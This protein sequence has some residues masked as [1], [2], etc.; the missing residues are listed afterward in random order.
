M[1][2]SGLLILVLSVCLLSANL[3]Q[4]T[5]YYA[6]NGTTSD[7][8]AAGNWNVF[9][10]QN[11]AWTIPATSTPAATDVVCFNGYLGGN[12][13][14]S[15][16]IALPDGA[17]T[18]NTAYFGSNGTQLNFSN[19]AATLNVTGN[20]YFS[21]SPTTN[22]APYGASTFA[23]VLNVTGQFAPQLTTYGAILNVTSSGNTFAGGINVLG[24]VTNI[25]GNNNAISGGIT[26]IGTTFD[27]WQA[28]NNFA[29]MNGVLKFSGTGNTFAAQTITLKDFGCLDL[30]SAQDLSAI[31]A[32]NFN[33]GML[34]LDTTA[35]TFGAMTGG[36]NVKSGSLWITGDASLGDPTLN[37]IQLGG[38]NS[39]GMLTGSTD[40]PGNSDYSP[41]SASR[42]ITLN[43][44]GGV[45]RVQCNQ[46][47]PGYLA[48]LDIGSKITGSGTLIKIG[49][50]TARLMNSGAISPTNDYSGGTINADSVLY[51][52]TMRTL[53]TGNVRVEPGAD[54]QLTAGT[55]VAATAKVLVNSGTTG[56]MVYSGVLD[57]C[58]Y[59]ANW[60][61]TTPTPGFMPTIDPASTGIVR[62]TTGYNCGDGQPI[63]T[64]L[65]A[66]IAG[67]GTNGVVWIGA[68]NWSGYYGSAL[69][70]G[71]ALPT[72]GNKVYRFSSGAV[73]EE[74]G[75][76]I[77][78]G[79]LVG[80]T[81]VW[82]REGGLNL[83]ATNT[84]TG[85]L[86]V[87]NTLYH[88]GGWWGW[89]DRG[90]LQ[91]VYGQA[92]TTA[93]ASPL[94][95]AAGDVKLMGGLLGINSIAAGLGVGKHDL[96]YSGSSYV[97]LKGNA[98]LASLSL[99]SLTRVNNGGLIIFPQTSGLGTTEQLLVSGTVPTDPTTGMVAPY[100]VAANGFATGDF[101]TY[102]STTGFNKFDGYVGMPASGG[103][104]TE[105]VNNT[106]TA[107][108]ADT[109]VW[110]MKSSG[111][112][113]G[114]GK[115][116]TLGSG[117]L[118]LA[119]NGTYDANLKAGDGAK[120]LVVFVNVN[121]GPW[122]N[123]SVFN[124]T[125]TAGGLTLFGAGTIRM[126][127]DNTATL[128]GD[129][130]VNDG[131]IQYTND[132]QF[133]AANNSIILNGGTLW[134]SYGYEA[135]INH[136]IKVGPAGGY[137]TNSYNGGIDVESEISDLDPLHS[138][139]V[140]FNANTN[141]LGVAATNTGGT[142]FDWGQTQL[143]NSGQP[144][145]GPVVIGPGGCMNVMRST[146]PDMRTS[147]F[148]LIS[149][150][151]N[152][153]IL[154]MAES[155]V[156]IGSLSGYGNV[157]FG[158]PYD[159]TNDMTMYVGYDN[160]S[161]DFYGN[162]EAADCRTGYLD[163]EG[164][165]TLTLWGNVSL[166]GGSATINGG[167]LKINGLYSSGSRGA[168]SIIVNNT[169]IL[170]GQGTISSVTV[171]AG[172]LLTGGMAI[173][174]SVLVN[175]G[176]ANLNG[177]TVTGNLVVG[178]NNNI[179]GSAATIANS[180]LTGAV[181]LGG[182]G[183]F[184]STGTLTA[185]NVTINANTITVNKGTFTGT[186]VTVNGSSTVTIGTSNAAHVGNITGTGNNFNLTGYGYVNLVNGTI[187]GSNTF[188]SNTYGF[189]INSGGYAPCSITGSNT[190]TTP[191]NA[192]FSMGKT[193]NGPDPA[194][195]TVV[196]GSNTINSCVY[197]YSGTLIGP[198]TIHGNTLGALV[199]QP[200]SNAIVS[201]HVGGTASTLTIG[202]NVTL[203]H[204]TVLNFNLGSPGTTGSGINDLIDITGNL[205]LDGTLNVNNLSGFG[206]GTYRLFNYTG[207]L[208]GPGLLQGTMP[209]DL[210]Y[211]IDTSTPGQINL[212]V[213]TP[214]IPG[215]TDH[216]G[217]STLNTLDIDAI[218]AHFGAASTSQWKVYPDT[219][220]VGQE[221]VTYEVAHYML[222]NYADANLD[223]Y[224]DFTDFQVLLDHWQAP[225]GWGDG[226][227]NGDGTVDFLDFQVL[228]DYWNP[229]GWSAGASQVPEPASLS[230]LLLGGLA[231][232]RR[233]K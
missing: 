120:E 135:R 56:S 171:N 119:G 26:V 136:K 73:N 65:A 46:W 157:L 230:L 220:P 127:A 39:L 174:G 232:L 67:D 60:A 194:A 68:Q 163:K 131:A 160:T 187:S 227:F 158:T 108:S 139:M 166:G 196:S 98:G 55:N 9:N 45:L 162:I 193:T 121:Q 14:G 49:C 231:L 149:N 102:N 101:L 78:T 106:G 74:A 23:S 179:A 69:A 123:G 72:G 156:K 150:N 225:G 213:A 115:T 34:K 142:S 82:V 13:T 152:V 134:S 229:T 165:G 223:R 110:A 85:T 118:I 197:L 10:D 2:R 36:F 214:Y 192:F 87:Q 202:G 6:W 11:G 233:K 44:E 113:G 212:G 219:N 94:G 117:G 208:T 7:W 153:S 57:L 32:I 155:G 224:T 15:A 99:T 122:D 35:V 90:N 147:A 92:Q 25:T 146:V 181:T 62:L 198:N 91:G 164:T 33:G 178:S 70:P 217:G 201:P 103:A 22:Q 204:S 209:A 148:T 24:Q 169:A 107:L 124:G 79:V 173:N 145:P 100:I 125:I 37:N 185:N 132:N 207:T 172:G 58:G 5:F 170:T 97:S 17:T 19:P 195:N 168:S 126:T 61:S 116:L 63:V 151:Q 161:T 43:G 154:Q 40:S 191:A 184:T 1:R 167:T 83:G 112:V 188:T 47:D 215:D 218:Y 210:T 16:T 144:G 143:I 206:A 38:T 64:A 29:S 159:P 199:V 138:G 189:Y 130:T 4:A 66:G 52:D 75:L 53:G 42:T 96:S 84:F 20:F 226:D 200:N 129:I 48:T 221:D 222:T 95:S 76:Y 28:A 133:G 128:V 183:T 89:G 104:G 30:A 140:H 93:G 137:L 41:T 175:G 109:S 88:D 71:Q 114:S 21:S 111:S 177:A 18:V 27:S 176:T 180:T 86:T 228:L 190:I 51:V 3:A 59:T 12:N 105:I 8:A 216:S 211:T 203:D 50:A 81:D 205:S 182:R 80:D 77:G 141:L 54:L 31:A 186:N